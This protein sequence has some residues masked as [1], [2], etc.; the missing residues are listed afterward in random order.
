MCYYK[1]IHIYGHPFII[2]EYF[3]DKHY[4]CLSL[5]TDC[6]FENLVISYVNMKVRL[7]NTKI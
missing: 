7:E 2:I 5:M 6:K 3:S 1:Y 4:N